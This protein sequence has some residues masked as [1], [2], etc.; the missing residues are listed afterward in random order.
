M[1]LYSRINYPPTAKKVL[2]N[3][4]IAF[5]TSHFLDTSSLDH[6]TFFFTARLKAPANSSADITASSGSLFRECV[7]VYKSID[8][9]IAGPKGVDFYRES[10][11]GLIIA[12]DVRSSRYRSRQTICDPQEQSLH[13]H[14]LLFLPC[15]LRGN[16]EE[17]KIREAIKLALSQNNYI[18]S[19]RPR[20]TDGRDINVQKFY[21]DK[22]LWNIVDYCIKADEAYHAD[23]EVAEK[24]KPF[25]FPY[26]LDIWDIHI[27]TQ[28]RKTEEEVQ[29]R[30]HT[31]QSSAS[32]NYDKLTIAPWTFYDSNEC[33]DLSKKHRRACG[34]G[35]SFDD[36][37]LDSSQKSKL[38]RELEA[39]GGAYIQGEKPTALVPPAA[40]SKVAREK[41]LLLDK[42]ARSAVYGEDEPLPSAQ[43]PELAA[44]LDQFCNLTQ[45]AKADTRYA[46]C[47]AYWRLKRRV[48]SPH[49]EK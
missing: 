14:G 45:W 28:K 49:Q 5:A 6:R 7:S 46:M 4:Y 24:F 13:V 11:C 23:G 20:E 43:C 41:A 39:D 30:I 17:A 37:L 19:D 47:Q 44:E 10:R 3:R 35:V 8:R 21:P 31:L 36:A 29:R 32:N 2:S 25:A 34:Q 22:P 18:K 40:K 15:C 9:Q 16:E 38:M 26:D 42:V 27:K 1:M 12:P 33:R 48:F